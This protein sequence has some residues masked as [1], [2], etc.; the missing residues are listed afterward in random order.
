LAQL[1]LRYTLS[2]PVTTA[3]TPGHMNFLRWA[4]E[5]GQNF[6]PITEDEINILKE[7]SQGTEPLFKP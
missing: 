2:Q 4:M 5:V 7:K 6:T 1:A 3:L